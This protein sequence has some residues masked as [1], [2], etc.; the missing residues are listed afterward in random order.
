MSTSALETP[1]VMAVFNRPDLTRRVFARV[2]EARPKRLFV[3][4]DG[5]RAQVPGDQDK[6]AQT[7]A[8]FESIDWDC[9]LETDYS[10]C[11]LGCGDRIQTGLSRV[12]DTVPEAIVVE[13][14]ILPHPSFFP[15]CAELLARYR[16]E[17]KVHAI[18]GTKLPC[19][20]RTAPYS[21]RFSRLFFSWGWAGFARAW[22]N[23]DKTL[24]AYPRI[25]GERWLAEN[26]RTETERH[27]YD[28]GFAAA[29]ARRIVHWDWAVIFSAFLRGELFAVPDRNLVSN[30]GWG[31][32]GTQLKNANHILADLPVH[33]MQFPLTHPPEIAA[34]ADSDQKI[35]DMIGPL[36]GPRFVRFFRKRARRLKR[37][38]YVAKQ[39]EGAH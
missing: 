28:D 12:F 21:Y 27:F 37:D 20:P 32:E 36:T 24:S 33:A 30:I 7:R 11:N 18:L 8:V 38:Y 34:D 22:R 2:R 4:A 14:D 1:V 5:P 9:R 15:Y 3:I 13:D 39:A 6:C 17:P 35:Y 19:E 10:E 16:D 23:V 29:Q 31:P 26:T 25:A